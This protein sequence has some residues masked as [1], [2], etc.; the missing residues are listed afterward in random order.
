VEAQR[1]LWENNLIEV[2]IGGEKE[3]P[4]DKDK[5]K[6]WKKHLYKELDY[7]MD[8]YKIGPQLKIRVATTVV[9]AWDILKYTYEGQT[10]VHLI[11]LYT[12]I[13]HLKYDDRRDGSL[14]NHITKF[15][16]H[17]LKLVQVAQAGHS[18]KDCLAQGIHPLTSSDTW[19]D[20]FLQSI[21]LRIQL[22]LNIIDNITSKDD[23]PSYSGIVMRLG[24]SIPAR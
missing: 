3:Q 15:E 21:L 1:Q 6:S 10:R 17:W 5:V 16:G 4:T 18:T 24:R 12:N 9:Q 14:A 19:K 7:L 2:V 11:S 22:Y 13:I 20:A 23:K 8:S